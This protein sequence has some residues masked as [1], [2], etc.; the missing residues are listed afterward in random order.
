MKEV[1]LSKSSWFPHPQK[2][3]GR[4]GGRGCSATCLRRGLCGW[5]TYEWRLERRRC[6]AEGRVVSLICPCRR[7]RRRRRRVVWPC[8]RPSRHTART[9]CRRSLTLHP[10]CR[11]RPVVSTHQHQQHW[12][13]TSSQHTAQIP[14][15]NVK[16]SRPTFW[17]RPQTVSLGLASISLSYY[18][19][20]HF[21]GKNRVKFG[22]FGKF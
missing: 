14:L 8:R 3:G 12:T 17:P 16:F 18:V 6:T 1:G 19:I 2:P 13:I 7:R 4:E 10:A 21:C 9:T 20:G 22:N 11:R 5:V 15:N